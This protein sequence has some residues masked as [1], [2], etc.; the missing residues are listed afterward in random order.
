MTMRHRTARTLIAVGCAVAAMGANAQST[1]LQQSFSSGLGSFTKTGK[2]TT[3]ANGAVLQAQTFSAD[4]AITSPA[5][6]TSG[7]SNVVVTYTRYTKGMTSITTDNGVLEMS[8][9]GGAFTKVETTRVTTPTQTSITL[10]ANAGNSSIKLRFRV[11]GLLTSETFVVNNLTVT[12]S[13]G[14]G[15]GGTGVTPPAGDYVTFEAAPVRPMAVSADGT[16]LYVCNTP[17]ARIEVFDVTGNAPVLKES[18]PV[19]MEPVSVA[20]APNGQLWVAN[21]LSD[22]ISIVDTSSSPA[23]IVNT[24]L[25]GDEPRDIV[26]A[27]PGNRYAYITAAHRGQNTTKYFPYDQ[28][29]PGKGRADVWVFDTQ[30]LGNELGGKAVK[31]INMFGDTLRGLARNADGTRVYAAALNSS[32]KTT[33]IMGG[34]TNVLAKAGPTKAADGT[35]AEATSLIVKQAADG[36]WYDGGDVDRGIAPKKWSS[37]VK[38]KMPDYDVFTINASGSNPEVIAK[39]PTVGTTLFNVAVNPVNGKVYVS[40]QDAR[41]EIRFEGPGKNS[42]TVRAHFVDAQITVIDGDGSNVKPRKLN[43]HI[44]YKQF[45]GT[46]DNRAKAVATPVEM[47]VTP[48][49]KT[50]YL[51]SLGTNR[52]VRYATSELES[53]TFQPSTSNILNLTG[54][55]PTGVALDA[56]R[57]RAYVTTRYDNGVSVVDTSSFKEVGHTTMHNPEPAQVVQGRKFLYDATYTS[58]HGDSSCAGCHIFNDV[59]YLGWD[60][61][62]PDDVRV[63]NNMKYNPVVPVFLRT[64]PYFHPMKGP[65]T[66]Q[67]FRGMKGNGPLHWRGDRQGVSQGDTFEERSFKDFRGAFTGLLGREEELTETEM[68][69]MAKYVMNLT[70]PPNPNAPL[71]LNY[72][73]TAKQ[74]RDFFFNN[75]ADTL[76]TCNGCHRTDPAKGQFG[77][78]GALTFEGPTLAANFKVAQLRNMYQ[79]VGFFGRNHPTRFT[80]MGEQLRGFGYSAGGEQGTVNTFLDA[81]V[82]NLQV[83]A[84]TRALL[85]DF[86]LAFPSDMTPMV[87]QQVT[88]TADS[89]SDVTSRLN[90]MVERAKVMTP[91]QECE[92]IAKAVISGAKRG[93]VMS[94]SG[95]AFVSNTGESV[96][97]SSLLSQGRSANAPLTFTCVPPGNGTRMG[98]DRKAN[99]SKES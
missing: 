31:V 44:D 28:S 25:V 99:G 79:K 90:M 55:M 56:T 35:E 23:K 18:I 16:R 2:V 45:V 37:Q 39:S 24:L 70:Y 74:G 11:N 46:A 27:G 86:V 21:H 85:E 52:L 7:Y 5:I 4:G 68:T 89:G 95:D 93:W 13:T 48:D 96:T 12:G 66:T 87:G 63:K 81:E 92:L 30:N 76:A 20:I 62:N 97:L 38:I 98:I 9:N 47:A 58:S 61:G 22:S 49:G 14:G 3:G 34:P 77:T 64:M 88:V 41:N 1:I 94:K 26:F 80:D 51:A 10:P 32:N 8:V 29:T 19:G 91:R 69:Q 43:K 42:T 60:L 83:S 67:S 75:N 36:E 33:V 40:N 72:T 84:A 6:S 50:L 82:F 15:T 53:D 59:D 71:D 57:N 54:G 73:G 17:D 78:D 65:L